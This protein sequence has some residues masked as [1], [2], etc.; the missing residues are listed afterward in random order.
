MHQFEFFIPAVISRF[1]YCKRDIVN[2]D[3]EIAKRRA[4]LSANE[5]ATRYHQGAGDDTSLPP[6]QPPNVEG[7]FL[8]GTALS[9][10]KQRRLQPDD[11]AKPRDFH[12]EGDVRL[13]DAVPWRHP[14][15]QWFFADFSG[16]QPRVY[17]TSTGGRSDQGVFVSTTA[18]RS[19]TVPR[20]HRRSDSRACLGG[21]AAPSVH[22]G[23][24]GSTSTMSADQ[25]LFIAV[26]R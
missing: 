10:R 13:K 11:G 21:R 5:N 20:V 7:R 26:R 19:H 3:V 25:G 9:L 12:G 15:T 16:E 4:K 8:L 24:A 17:P 22:A 23:A 14:E 1:L 2:L 6:I 18:S